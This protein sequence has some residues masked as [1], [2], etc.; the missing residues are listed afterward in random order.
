MNKRP[1]VLVVANNKGGVGKSLICQLI[2]TYLSYKKNQKVLTLDFDPQGNMSY[3]FLRDTRAREMSSYRPPIHPEFDPND[4]D[5]AE[6]GGMSSALDM[7]TGEPVVPYPTELENLDILP[8]NASLIRAIENFEFITSLDEIIQR[9][10]DFFGLE[11]VIEEGYDVVVIDTPPAKG[12]LTQAAIRAASHV[13]IPIEL[14]NKSLQGLAGMI[15]LIN[16]QNAYR[17]KSSQTKII[18]LLQNKVAYNKRGPQNKVIDSISQDAV[19]GNLLL[20]DVVLHDS[21]RAVEIDHDQAPVTMPYELKDSDRFAK[22]AVQLGEYVFK[23][24]HLSSSRDRQD[25]NLTVRATNVDAK[26]AV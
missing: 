25:D 26:E 8:S 1:K 5:D 15:D 13:L 20:E 21:P 7:W 4:P 17:P 9:P 19:L 22:E 16:R 11:D 3:R 24:L 12:P 14:S 6:W 18:G 23:S 10:Y 2:A